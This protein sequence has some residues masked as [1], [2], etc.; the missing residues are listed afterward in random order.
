MEIS[1][2]GNVNVC[3][4]F[5]I[6]HKSKY[7][8]KMYRLKYIYNYLESKMRSLLIMKYEKL[9]KYMYFVTDYILF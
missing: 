2:I 6:F 1:E 3:R 4:R 9:E 7:N 5:E 8:I